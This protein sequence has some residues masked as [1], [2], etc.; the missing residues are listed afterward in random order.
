M[1]FPV[2]RT[3]PLRTNHKIRLSSALPF[4]THFLV[5]F[6]LLI[7]A[8]TG[9]AEPISTWVDEDGV[10][11]F[12]SREDK[13]STATEKARLPDIQKYDSDSMIESLKEVA[14]KTCINRGGVDCEAGPAPDGTVICADG[15]KGSAEQY[16]GSC[17]QIRLVSS[18]DVP[19]SGRADKRFLSVPVK[20][21]VRNESRI[22]A[23]DVAVRASF[24]ES[25]SSESRFKLLLEGPDT[26]PPFE[27]AHYTYSGK[28][29]D[30]RIARRGNIKV[31]CRECW[32]P[33]KNRNKQK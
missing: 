25:L 7:N 29:L 33:L 23:T 30:V 5:S 10:R 2:T 11:H 21:S 24:H 19:E 9:N 13:E 27:I 3:T 26:I 28:L 18:L 8:C 17:T 31:T 4:F 1:R 32:D 15:Y 22:E 16:E 12:S 14:N 20:V 6:S